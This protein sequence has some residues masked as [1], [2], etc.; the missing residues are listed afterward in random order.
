MDTLFFEVRP[1]PGH[2]DHYFE[3]VARLRPVLARQTGLVFLD[4]YASLSDPDVLLSHQLWENEEAIMAWRKDATHRQS[5]SAGRAVHFADY[6]IRVG[7]RVRHWRADAPDV[8]TDVTAARDVPHVLALY[9][10]RAMQAPDVTAFES[11]NHKGRFI[12]LMTLS[13]CDPAVAMM[14]AQLGAEGL[15]EAAVYSIRRD[16]GLFDRDQA[17]SRV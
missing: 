5:Q 14:Q 15:E 2:L 4:R 3:H 16:Y 6:R 8:T 12:A 17:P 9:G 11:V 7:T 1:H 13:G 10:T